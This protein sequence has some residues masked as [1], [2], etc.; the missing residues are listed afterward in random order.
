MPLF[1]VGHSYINLFATSHSLAILYSPSC[2]LAILITLQSNNLTMSNTAQ[3][4]NSIAAEDA[5]RRLVNVLQQLEVT[6]GQA[7]RLQN[8]PA[9]E[10]SRD[11]RL[12]MGMDIAYT[13]VGH[14]RQFHE[15]LTEGYLE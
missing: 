14:W 15:Y 12:N 1:A 7:L 11:A 6:V 5:N 2:R 4:S 8:G 13:L 10:F 3:S 9:D